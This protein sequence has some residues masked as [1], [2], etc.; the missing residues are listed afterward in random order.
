MFLRKRKTKGNNVAMNN[1]KIFQKI[2]NQGYLS[3]NKGIM[4]YG[5]IKPLHK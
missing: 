5:K 4:K 1:I 3:V 2:R